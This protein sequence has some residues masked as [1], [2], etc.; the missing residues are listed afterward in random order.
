M[1]KSLVW[2]ALLFAVMWAS[3][4]QAANVQ[5]G[6][7]VYEDKCAGCHGEDGSANTAIG[8]AVKAADLRSPATNQKTD[9]EIYQQIEKGKGNMPP[10]GSSLNKD[11]INDLIAYVRG[12]AKGQAAGR[13]AH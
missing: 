10:F 11:Q 1:R 3:A 13:K 12:F 6:K 9:A 5:E 2:V 7:K 8:Q 4:S